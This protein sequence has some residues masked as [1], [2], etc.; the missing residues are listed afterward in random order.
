MN[1][2]EKR[3]LFTAV[4]LI[5]VIA[6]VLRLLAAWPGLS[7]VPAT[8]F[9]L[10]TESYL[11]PALSLTYD[12]AYN[13]GIGSTAPSVGR[14]PG[15]PFFLALCFKCFGIVYAVPVVI[16]CA[17]GALTC[18]PV[19][20]A[21]RLLGGIRVGLIAAGL[22]ALNIT[23]IANSPMYLTDS[24]YTFLVA[25]QLYFWVLFYRRQ[26]VLFCTVAL[27][28]AAAGTLV[29]PI[30]LVW[31]LPA[32]F[33]ICITPGINFKKKAL[34]AGLSLLVFYGIL[35]PWMYRNSTLG[36]GYCI[37]VNTGA[38]YHQNGAMLM[39]KI[40]GKPYEVE[41]QLILKE[42]DEELKD[43]VKYPDN[44]S[45]VDYRLKKLKALIIKHPFIYFSLHFKPV[46]LLPDAPTF[47]E[48]LGYT[49]SDRGTLDVMQ[50]HGVIAAV[51]HYFQ[52][53]MWLLLLVIPAVAIAGITYAGCALQ[54]GVW[55]WKRKFFMFFVFLAFVE[56]FLFMPGPITVPRYHL[57]ALPLMTIMAGSGIVFVFS[58]WK[59]FRAKTQ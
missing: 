59:K 34:A 51:K 55:L 52:G 9:R 50:Q 25:W 13:S 31:I 20:L 30:G 39:S 46:I 40:T 32:L 18:L 53:Q 5:C 38:M 47:F 4:I 6:F 37:D 43:K 7:N 42:L 24:L 41:K 22:F 1:L 12:N 45:Q 15:F 3:K 58:K 36:A 28:L 35:L 23:A 21:G 27:A 17:I 57:P 16:L 48:I 10:D 54:L 33:L 14:A 2:I 49:K 19:F 29:R 8:F 26:K 44:K 56:Y 11:Q